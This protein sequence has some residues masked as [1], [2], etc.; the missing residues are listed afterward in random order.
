MV[1]DRKTFFCHP[2]FR[3]PSLRMYG[4]KRLPLR[5]I[6]FSRLGGIEIQIHRIIA[7]FRLIKAGLL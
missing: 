3:S 2:I 5:I 6:L 4:I 1:S 7:A